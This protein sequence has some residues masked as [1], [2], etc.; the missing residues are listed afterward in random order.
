MQIAYEQQ[1]SL[2]ALM[3]KT[4]GPSRGEGS[5]EFFPGRGKD[6]RGSCNLFAIFLQKI[7]SDKFPPADGNLNGI[8]K[9]TDLHYYYT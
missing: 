3:N 6:Y 1:A 9:K 4:A 2:N 7:G 8:E 5:P